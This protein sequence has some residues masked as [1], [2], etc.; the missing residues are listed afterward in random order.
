MDEFLL[1]VLERLTRRLITRQ[2]ATYGASLPF[3]K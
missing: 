1:R 2:R 3:L